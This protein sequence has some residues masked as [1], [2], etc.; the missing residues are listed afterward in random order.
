MT[1]NPPPLKGWASLLKRTKETIAFYLVTVVGDY[2]N[3][4]KTTFVF[5]L[6]F[7]MLL[8]TNISLYIVK[9]NKNNSRIFTKNFVDFQNF[10]KFNDDRI[11]IETNI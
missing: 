8:H 6:I 5:I 3:T 4:M 1:A 9:Q 7:I 10:Q 2:I 11:L